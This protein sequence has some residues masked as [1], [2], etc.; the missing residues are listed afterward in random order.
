MGR[1]GIQFASVQLCGR[2]PSL[3]QTEIP[4]WKCPPPLVRLGGFSLPL[5]H[6]GLNTRPLSS[7]IPDVSLCVW[8]SAVTSLVVHPL[9]HFPHLFPSWSFLHLLHWS[10]PQ[11]VAQVL[12]NLLCHQREISLPSGFI[13]FFLLLLQHG[14]EDSLLE[15]ACER[16]WDQGCRQ[17]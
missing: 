4:T 7:P 3:M 8:C 16:K 17:M 11:S 9:I 13:E 15:A 1:T 6:W 12:G 5:S 2:F 10:P 14:K